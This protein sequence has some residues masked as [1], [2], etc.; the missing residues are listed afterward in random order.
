MRRLPLLLLLS[1]VPSVLVAQATLARQ[2]TLLTEPGGRTLATLRSGAPVS[3]STTTRRGAT[4]VTIEGWIHRST[5]GGKRDEFPLSV[6]ARSGALLRAAASTNG[7]V[8]AKL[9]YGMGLHQVS[10]RGQWVRV[11]RT[12]WL[13]TAALAAERRREPPVPDETRA[14]ALQQRRQ[15]PSRD[16]RATQPA[17]PAPAPAADA[18]QSDT[19]APRLTSDAM[20]TRRT[21]PLLRAPGE[22][23]VASV[24]PG[25][26][27]ETVARDRGWVRVRVEGWV[28]DS[29]LV[30]AD[31]AGATL[32]AADIRANPDAARGRTVHWEVQKIS[33]QIADAL[34]KDMAQDEPYLLARGPGNENALLYLTLPP[35]L[36][37]RAR[38]L[39][40]LRTIRITARVRNGRSE[41]AGI[42]VLD[43][44]SL[45]PK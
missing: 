25:A 12:A 3:R 11:R 39:P 8:L 33:F 19:S 35:S 2:A 42:P 7:R 41:P 40:A 34:R 31:T 27:L 14:A 38:A 29:A 28:R 10:R 15:T 37:E 9:E 16:R 20:T 32:S 6:T 17:R 30:P 44:I 22:R 1:L 5:L 18:A 4:R 13:P 43:V 21:L 45:T 36:V 26:R 23:A 24:E